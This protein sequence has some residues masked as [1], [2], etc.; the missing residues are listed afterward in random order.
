[1]YI[2]NQKNSQKWSFIGPQPV[3]MGIEHLNPYNPNSIV[4]GYAV[5]EKAMDGIR[6]ELIIKDKKGY[7]ITPKNKCDRYRYIRL[8]LRII[9][10]LMVNIL[11][12]IKKENLLNYL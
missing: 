11:L 8:K 4:S 6:A 7:L 12:K 5:T 1:M 3:S 10:Y 2:T 9:G